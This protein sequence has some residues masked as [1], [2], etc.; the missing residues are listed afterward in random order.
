MQNI[1]GGT[2]ANLV[3]MDVLVTGRYLKG[4]IYWMGMVG[5]L[6]DGIV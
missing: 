6:R 5:G 3:K 1:F 4:L 2:P